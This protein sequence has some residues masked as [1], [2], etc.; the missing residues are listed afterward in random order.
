MD[1]SFLDAYKARRA[2][3]LANQRPYVVISGSRLLL[4]VPGKEIPPITVIPESYHALKDIAHTPF[5]AYLLLSPV[6]QGVVD[7]KSQTDAL[8]VLLGRI[9]NAKTEVTAKWFTGDEVDRANRILDSTAEFVR[10][11]LQSQTVSKDSLDAFAKTLGPLMLANAWDAGCA[12]IN[13]THAQ[14]MLWKDLLSSDN[15]RQLTAVNRARHQARYRNA[16]TQYFSWL[17]DVKSTSWSYSGESM[18]VIYVESLGPG[19]DASDE[20]ATVLIDADA[21][22][23]FFGDRWRLSEDILSEGAAACIEKLPSMSRY[24]Q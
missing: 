7:L 4:H 20:L 9:D 13:A 18:R 2:S 24:K 17:F 1:K 10:H 16:A 21:S 23:A 3:T 5:A 11:T 12:Q 19:E 15:W 6:E 8:N 14:M 22:Q